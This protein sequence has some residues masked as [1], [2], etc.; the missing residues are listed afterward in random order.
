MDDKMIKCPTCGEVVPAGTENCP[1]CGAPIGVLEGKTVVGTPINNTAAINEML[2]NSSMLVE[3]GKTLGVGDLDSEPD[4]ED[5]EIQDGG[6]EP[7]S[8]DKLTAAQEKALK[9]GG[10]IELTPPD[11]PAPSAD[12]KKEAAPAA[13]APAAAPGIPGFPSIPGMEEPSQNNGTNGGIQIFDFDE[14]ESENDKGEKKSKRQGKKKKSGLSTIIAVVLALVIGVAAGFFGKIFL[15]PDMPVPSCQ[16]FAEKSAEAVSRVEG[17]DFCILKAYVNEGT[18]AKQCLINAI[19]YDDGAVAHWYRV[20]V[21]NGSE[22]TVHVYLE[23]EEGEYEKLKNSDDDGDK[24][25][26]AM[27]SS[28]W[29]ETQRC[30]SEIGGDN[31]VEANAAALNNKINPYK[32]G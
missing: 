21:E 31:W 8:L 13:E 25:K 1:G 7:P 4:E 24:I 3:E 27:L 23:P 5:E 2:Q 9:A 18:T 26:A 6:Y 19:T 20:K 30:I 12:K 10:V 16:G 14:N 32:K 17:K 28:I 29:E 22:D 11:A 15:L